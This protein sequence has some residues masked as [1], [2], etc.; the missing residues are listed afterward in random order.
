[1]LRREVTLTGTCEGVV[2][3]V[4]N[5]R[6]Y[7]D[8]ATDLRLSVRAQTVGSFS[9]SLRTARHIILRVAVGGKLL[10]SLPY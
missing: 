5:A 2:R 4:D 8:V 3:V 6:L 1:M 7:V 10:F 9:H